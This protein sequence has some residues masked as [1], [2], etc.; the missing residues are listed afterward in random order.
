MNTTIIPITSSIISD[1]ITETVLARKLHEFLGVGRHYRSWIKTRIASYG[2]IENEGY[3]SCRPKR[4]SKEQGGQN[5]IEH[6]F[7]LDMTK[8]LAMVERNEKGREARR[9][10]IGCEKQL[11]EQ[12][13]TIEQPKEPINQDKTIRT[14]T[15]I[16]GN[17]SIETCLLPSDAMIIS[18]SELPNLIRHSEYFETSALPEIMKS[19]TER[20]LKSC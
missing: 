15:V 20:I 2:F 11:K 5:A 4:V 16:R 6:Y 19:V 1:S 9:Y 7:T 13:E 18:P 12:V 14:M 8:E 10:F 3:I 17:N